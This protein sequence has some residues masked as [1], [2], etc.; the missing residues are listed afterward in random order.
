MSRGG[1]SPIG[2]PNNEFKGAVC[3]KILPAQTK[4]HSVLEVENE[5]NQATALGE[6]DLL[7]VCRNVW[8]WAE[9]EGYDFLIPTLS[10]KSPNEGEVLGLGF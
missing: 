2:R 10:P 6:E 4:Q 1:L 7:H 8:V 9:L 3:E 5:S